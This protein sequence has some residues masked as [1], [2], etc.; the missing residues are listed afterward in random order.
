MELLLHWQKN[1][2]S[3]SQDSVIPEGRDM[4]RLYYVFL[5]YIRVG[6]LDK[7]RENAACCHLYDPEYYTWSTGRIRRPGNRQKGIRGL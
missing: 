1:R 2:F 4:R 3:E 6:G 7:K 5:F